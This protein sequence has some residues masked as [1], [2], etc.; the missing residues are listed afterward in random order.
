[1][2]RLAPAGWTDVQGS[3]VG[4]PAGPV[5]A[6]TGVAD[7]GSFERLLGASL[8]GQVELLA[9]PDHHA[10]GASDARRIRALAGSR[11]VVVTE[12]DAVKLA[13]LSAELPEVRVLVLAVHPE[14]GERAIEDALQRTVFGRA[15]AAEA[16]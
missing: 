9:F 1:V 14:R 12:K 6:V 2:L 3:P 5:L 10:F 4:P 8:P 16:P 15:P 7:P 13:A 11:T